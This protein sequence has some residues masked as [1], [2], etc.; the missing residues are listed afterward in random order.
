MSTRAKTQGRPPGSIAPIGVSVA[1]T[2]VV[3]GVERIGAWLTLAF[4]VIGLPIA[5]YLTFIHY[6]KIKPVCTAG[7]F[8]CAGVLSSPYSVV[9]PTNMPITVPGFGWFV[10]SGGVAAYALWTYHNQ[11]L[12][13]S[14]LIPAHMLWAALGVVF[15]LYLIYTEAV[16]LHEVCEW[17]TGVH[18]LVILSF[19]VTLVR[20]Q[21]NMAARYR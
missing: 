14:W 1:G 9:G 11:R 10:V 20:W 21:R 13:P 12:L 18:I 2:T 19:L 3:D 16:L 4:A 7:V 8:N 5:V 17:C 6:A 15:V